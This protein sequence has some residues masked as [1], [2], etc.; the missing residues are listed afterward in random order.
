MKIFDE[1][2]NYVL[3]IQIFLRNDKGKRII[4]ACYLTTQKYPCSF[5]TT[6][7]E[8]QLNH[9]AKI[10]ASIIGNYLK[11]PCSKNNPVNAESHSGDSAG[12]KPGACPTAHRTKYYNGRVLQV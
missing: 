11:N 1:C 7:R 2:Y 12:K 6:Y 9:P 8:I 10:Y 3:N 5:G 4:R